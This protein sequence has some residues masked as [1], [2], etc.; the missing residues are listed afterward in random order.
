MRFIVEYIWIGAAV[1]IAGGRI[2]RNAL[3]GSYSQGTPVGV[4]QPKN[5]SCP[6]F[7]GVEYLVQLT[8]FRE[9]YNRKKWSREQIVQESREQRRKWELYY[10]V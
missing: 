5:N 8:V 2:D 4:E 9:F 1:I 10:I 6:P 3:C 7:I